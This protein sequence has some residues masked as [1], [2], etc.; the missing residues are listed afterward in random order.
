VSLLSSQTS[1][2]LS[3]MINNKYKL[4]WNFTGRLAKTII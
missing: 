4:R 2:T 1:V 3:L